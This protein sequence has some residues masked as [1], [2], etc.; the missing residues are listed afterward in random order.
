MEK[1][2]TK[3]HQGEQTMIIC[4]QSILKNL[5]KLDQLDKR[6]SESIYGPWTND[7]CGRGVKM[8]I[9]VVMYA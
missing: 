6:Q 7:P 5:K 8:E 9:W 4:R 2:T 3:F 1:I